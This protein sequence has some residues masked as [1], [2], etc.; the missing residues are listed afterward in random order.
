MEA[1]DRNKWTNEDHYILS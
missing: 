1:S